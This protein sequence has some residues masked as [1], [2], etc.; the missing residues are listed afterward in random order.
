MRA[1]TR[2]AAVAAVLVAA[3][4][5][6]AAA[7][8]GGS[9]AGLTFVAKV[10][11]GPPGVAGSTGCSAALIKSRYVLT[12][13]S[14]FPDLTA[15]GAP[16]RSL[17]VTV[18]GYTVPGIEVLPHPDRDVA[19]IRLAADLP[20]AATPVTMAT[21]PA[22][23]G[24]SVYL[25]GYGRTAGE[26][27]PDQPHTAPASV[28]S[29]GTSA[30]TVRSEAGVTTCRG[31]AGGP[32]YLLGGGIPVL[33]GVHA[34]SG[35]QGC[36]GSDGT[37]A[38]ATESR[39]DDLLPWIDEQLRLRS[40]P[41]VFHNVGTT[42]CLAINGGNPAAGTPAI[43][44][45]CTDPPDHRWQ[46]TALGG[47]LVQLKNG[48]T[49][50]CLSVKAATAVNAPVTQQA[51]S[52]VSQQWA[53]EPMSD[54]SVRYRN[55]QNNGCLAVP[56]R[57]TEAGR[58][59]ITWTCDNTVRTEQQW[60]AKARDLSRLLRNKVTNGCVRATAG[61]ADQG[62]CVDI[63]AQR[64][65]FAH[66]SASTTLVNEATRQCL[67]VT[68]QVRGSQIV[69]AACD[70]GDDQRWTITKS[71]LDNVPVMR[72][73]N[74]FSGFCMGVSA[75]NPAEGTRVIQ[76]TCGSLDHWFRV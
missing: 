28:S 22:A 5:A 25:A 44:W 17:T 49:N 66:T 32:A 10:Q 21:A 12:A 61:K 62:N 39:T 16:R 14:C 7:V 1:F 23:A 43:Q 54:G 57:S 18:P 46:L 4:A 67:T 59:L 15:A 76:W 53:A 68:D 20:A 50:L 29:V 56:A 60:T 33:L 38:G 65:A 19:L 3:A 64:F 30:L 6:P 35:Q 40:S 42:F 63:A 52:G 37:D 26:W 45:Y 31:D 73:Q 13:R 8:V 75:A 47:N 27:V 55:K 34:G 51:C 24:D 74:A 41:D 72:F 2:V 58:A 69:L 9:P 70:G 71:T 11:Y 48:G 36:L